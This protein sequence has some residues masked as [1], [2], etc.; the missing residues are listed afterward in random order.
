MLLALGVGA[1][2]YI[3]SIISAICPH[4]NISK[5]SYLKM[6][7]QNVP[8]LSIKV[9]RCEYLAKLPL[10]MTSKNHPAG[11]LGRSIN[12]LKYDFKNQGDGDHH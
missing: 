6:I 8:K 5:T 9:F 3:I 12:H 2:K 11:I 7:N 1:S 4:T 10:K